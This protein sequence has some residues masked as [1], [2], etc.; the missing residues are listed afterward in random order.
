MERFK[1]LKDIKEVRRFVGIR[2]AGAQAKKDFK[3]MIEISLGSY[4]L[5]K[6]MGGA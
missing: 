4:D 6:M 2:K 3:T 1:P 5:K